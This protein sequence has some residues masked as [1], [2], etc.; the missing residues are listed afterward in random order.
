MNTEA[1]NPRAVIGGNMPPET[2][3]PVAVVETRVNDLVQAANAWL[4]QVKE[5]TDADTAAACDSFLTQV[6]A[7]IKAADEERKR[8]NKPHDEAIKA[9]NDRFR[10]LT[11]LLTKINDLLNPLKTGWLKREQD[12]LA[13]E[14]RAAEEEARRKQEEAERATAQ[15]PT[16]VEDALRIEQAQKEAKDAIKLANRAGKAKA[17][18]RGDLSLR[19][20]GLR[21]YWFARITDYRKALKHYAD[22]QE[23]RDVVE[24]LAAADAR[25]MKD[26]LKVPGVES[27]SEQKAA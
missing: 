13:A 18:V 15:E 7:E 11:A 22:R 4:A 9:N 26:A 16:T 24:R 19:S 25:N 3:D 14:A 1:E 12:R 27:Y 2:I 23:V 8:L 5:I 17:Q 6:K 10:P 20:S 21:T